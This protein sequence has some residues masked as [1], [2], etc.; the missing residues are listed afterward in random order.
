MATLLDTSALVVLLRRRPP[1][2]REGV[3]ELTK[4]KLVAGEALVSVVTVTELTIGA[5]DRS[6]EARLEELL[7]RIPVV[8]LHRE[9][10]RRA[11]QMGRTARA[12][13]MTLPLSDLVIAATAA[14]LEVPLLT[15]DSDFARGRELSS[16]AR[17]GHPWHGFRLDPG[18][19][20]D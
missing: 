10:A 5:R 17:A 9:A 4:M 2:G 7:A 8:A 11:G 13:G 15:C 12:E 3:A 16:G 18:S 14:W 6:A 20:V 19:V 1:T